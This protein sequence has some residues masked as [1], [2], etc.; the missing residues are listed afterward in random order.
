MFYIS[1]PDISVHS[2]ESPDSTP[3]HGALLDRV[4]HLFNVNV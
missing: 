4:A 1:T 3:E 2:I